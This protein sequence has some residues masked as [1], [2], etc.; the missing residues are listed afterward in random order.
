MGWS[1]F[2]F[3]PRRP[4]RWLARLAGPKIV[5]RLGRDE[6]TVAHRDCSLTLPTVIHSRRDGVIV[7]VGGESAGDAH[8]EWI[9]DSSLA[10]D[11]RSA[12]LEKFLHFAILKLLDASITIRPVIR[13]ETSVAIERS[14]LAAILQRIGAAEVTFVDT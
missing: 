1:D 3:P 10:A 6:A 4:P 7:G 5:L 14:E 12:L 9:F 11:R 13:V 8:A 2:F